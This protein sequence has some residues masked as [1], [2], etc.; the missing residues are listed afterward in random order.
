MHPEFED[1]NPTNPFDFW[2]GCNLKLKI[3]MV[4]GYRNYDKS[5][6]DAI[7]LAADTDEQIEKLWKMQYPL[8]PFLAPDQFKS[9]ND[10][11]TRLDKVLNTHSAPSTSKVEEDSP[12][13]PANR[14]T[15][16]SEPAV[17]KS[18]AE[19]KVS[20]NDDLDFF[21]KLAEEDDQ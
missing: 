18:A 6:F 17:G 10:L 2:K 19:P 9:Y 15:K 12:W 16:V 3:R 4:E 21:R 8:Q 1:E 13:E 7:S 5:E 11:K 20:G 14:T